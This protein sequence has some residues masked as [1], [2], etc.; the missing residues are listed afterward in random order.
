MELIAA[1]KASNIFYVQ[2]GSMILATKRIEGA[3]KF[4]HAKSYKWLGLDLVPRKR[5]YMLKT[6]RCLKTNFKASAAMQENAFTIDLFIIHLSLKI[7][8]DL[9]PPKLPGCFGPGI[10]N[11]KQKNDRIDKNTLH[12]C[13]SHHKRSW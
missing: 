2:C 5:D 3:N 8:G 13:H 4:L 7:Y 11:I 10:R 9:E 12:C 1:L 6:F